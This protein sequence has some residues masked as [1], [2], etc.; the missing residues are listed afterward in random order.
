[1]SVLSGSYSRKRSSLMKE[2][3][4]LVL[5]IENEKQINNVTFTI[6]TVQPLEYITLSNHD[7]KHDIIFV[8]I[9]WLKWL[10]L[11]SDVHVANEDCLHTS[12]TEERIN[13]LSLQP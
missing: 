10:N 1:M 4:S 7:V 9:V 2:T 13:I 3:T 5:S 8:T 12:C 6:P 11:G